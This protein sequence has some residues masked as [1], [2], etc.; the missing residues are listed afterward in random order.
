MSLTKEEYL[1]AYEIIQC[2]R[3]ANQD[4]YIV[5]VIKNNET[6]QLRPEGTD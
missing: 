6:F 3:G 2:E 4:E 5:E 1:N